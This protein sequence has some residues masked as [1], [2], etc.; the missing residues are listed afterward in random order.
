MQTIILNKPAKIGVNKKNVKISEF[1]FVKKETHEKIYEP[2][3]IQQITL[4]NDKSSITNGAVKLLNGKSVS[5][6]SKDSELATLSYI[7]DSHEFAHLSKIMAGLPK[8]RVKKIGLVF[9]RGVCS[10]RI[11]VLIRLN[12]KRG[13]NSV[14]REHIKSMQLL[15]KQLAKNFKTSSKL[16]G[17]EG[18]IAKHFFAGIREF[19]PKGIGFQERNRDGEDLYNC[20]LNASHSIL[21]SKVHRKLLAHNVNPA[22]GFLH[23]QVDKRKPFLAWDFSEFWIPYMDKLCLYLIEKNIVTEKGQIIAQNGH[24]KWLSKNSWK[25]LYEVTGLRVKDDEIEKKILEFK[26]TLLYGKR[27]SWCRQSE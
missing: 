3:Q 10:Q 20:L 21:R 23:F 14:V 5:F 12:E 18:N 1:D 11:K 19:L 8:S 25:R 17:I 7:N 26:E 15:Q 6:I 27:F 2:Q 24:G 4:L 16:K 13:N 22:F 9:C